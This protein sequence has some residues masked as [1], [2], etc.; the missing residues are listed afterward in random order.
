MAK[1][2]TNKVLMVRP[3]AFYFNV[4]TAVNN[5][6][7]QK[8][9]ESEEVVQAKALKEFDALVEKM[10]AVGIQVDVCQDTR[11]PYTP[12]S[13][14]PNNWFVSESGGKLFLCPMFAPDRR[15]ERD[16]FLG[17]LVEDIDSEE[18]EVVD[19]AFEEKAGKFLEGTGAIVL[20]RVNRK[21]FAC[22][23]PRADVELFHKFCEKFN[24]Q[25]IE[26]SAY[27]TVDGKRERIYHTNVMMAIGE[28]FAVVCLDSIDDLTEKK[29]MLAELRASGKTVI[30][31]TEDQVSSFAGNIIQVEG[32]EGKMYTMMSKTAY[33][34]LTPEQRDIISA[35]TE[36]IFSDVATIESYGGGSVRCMIAEVF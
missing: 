18:I 11:E 17:K 9:N 19:Y 23:S 6:Y 33:L 5:F 29:M 27:Q 28:Q 8:G 20:D 12:D 26:F 1:Q 35:S 21:A 24:Y 14:Y 22:I 16:K 36:I 10:K 7:Q 30:E 34:A 25:P 15:I 2:V 3:A 4:E 32:A 13:I 31:I